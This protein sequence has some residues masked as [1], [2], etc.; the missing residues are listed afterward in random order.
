MV[1]SAFKAD[2]CSDQ[3]PQRIRQRRSGRIHDGVVIEPG[4]AE[5][6]RWTVEALPC[7][8]GDV[9]V[10]TAGR[11]K[12]SLVAHTLH[13]LKPKHVPVKSYGAFQ[14]RHFKVH[15]ADAHLRIDWLSA[16]AFRC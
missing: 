13:E 10:I 7:I 4:S 15:M 2:S 11:E 8:Q 16:F 3:T 5:R 14:V 12:C 9:M 1:C 6:R